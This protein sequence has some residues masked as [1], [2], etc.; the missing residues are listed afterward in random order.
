MGV[1]SREVSHDQRWFEQYDSNVQFP[2]PADV[3]AMYR[4]VARQLGEG[5]GDWVS[6]LEEAEAHFNQ[7]K[8]FGEIFD[9][10]WFE[11]ALP[12]DVPALIANDLVQPPEPVQPPTEPNKDVPAAGKMRRGRTSRAPKQHQRAAPTGRTPTTQQSLSSSQ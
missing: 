4:I 10:T 8:T 5:D 2:P 7:C 12:I 1:W 11:V 6:P 9:H 3:D